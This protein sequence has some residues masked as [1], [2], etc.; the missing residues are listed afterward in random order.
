MTYYVPGEFVFMLA[1]FF[2]III[3]KVVKHNKKK[4]KKILVKK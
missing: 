4:W 3:W 1:I 2:G